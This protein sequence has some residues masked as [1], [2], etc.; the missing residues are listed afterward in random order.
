MS[1]SITDPCLVVRT[2]SDD[3]FD[4]LLRWASGREADIASLNH[5]E[6]GWDGMG[7]SKGVAYRMAELLNIDV[8]QEEAPCDDN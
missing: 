5:D 4:L 6:H 8:L 1:F 3:R 2:E 7:A